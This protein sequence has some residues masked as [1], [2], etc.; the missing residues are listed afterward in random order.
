MRDDVAPGPMTLASGPQA[1][2][3]LGHEDARTF[4]GTTL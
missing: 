3:R 4:G 1:P 2:G